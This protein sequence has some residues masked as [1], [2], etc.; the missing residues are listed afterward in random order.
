MEEPSLAGSGIVLPGIETQVDN[1]LA[2]GGRLDDGDLVIVYG[3]ANDASLVAD[4]IETVPVDEIPGLI[5]TTAT[6]AVENLAD[7]VLK[8]NAAGGERFVLPNLADLGAT[9]SA[10]EQGTVIR[11]L[12]TGYTLAHNLALL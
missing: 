1:F 5:Q 12:G 11:T 3:G 10:R 6:T 7:S 9:P 4:V 2:D 8:L